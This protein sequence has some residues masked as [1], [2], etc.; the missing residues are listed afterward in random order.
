MAVKRPSARAIGL[1]V[2][3]FVLGGL[4]GGLGAT[5][6]RHIHESPRRERMIDRLSREL[7]L[8]AQQRSQIQ[9]ILSAGHK[10]FS[11]VFQQSQDQARSRYDAIRQDVHARIRAVLTP[12]QQ[13]KFDD[14][15][16]RL[17]A[18]HK[19]HP[20]PPPGPRRRGR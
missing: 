5:L 8:S 11:A 4:V 16:H 15:L 10:Q 7:Q 2:T 13:A 17:D 9:A 19:V 12:A 1:M 6:L 18:E 20:P 3:V 14:F